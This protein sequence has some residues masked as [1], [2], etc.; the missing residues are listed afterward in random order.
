MKIL[1]IHGDN[2]F[3]SYNKLR[4]VLNSSKEKGYR[5][6]NILNTDFNFKEKLSSKGL[7]PE[8]IIFLLE[9]INLLKSDDFLWI[10]NNVSI[11]DL[12]II[13][14]NDGLLGKT[15]INKLP[16]NTVINEYKLPQPLWKFLD[17][18][19]PENCNKSL[20]LLNEC[21]KNSPKEFIFT[22]LS[23]H[24]KDLYWAKIEPN[25]LDYQEWRITKLQNQAG[26]FSKN[27]L[28]SV[29]NDMSEIDL[30]VKTS[31]AELLSSLDFI[32]IEKLE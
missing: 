19:Y 20:Q 1:L 32:I 4:E 8:K 16:K 24:L 3:E 5:I 22:M 15:I 25:G 30:K 28:K 11:S 26:K 10:N 27:L 23:R 18:F 31:K 12:F 13:I 29:I 9:N 17:S 14:Y 6:E 7:F 2:T 21:I